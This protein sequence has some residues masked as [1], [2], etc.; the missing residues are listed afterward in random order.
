MFQDGASRRRPRGF[1]RKSSISSSSAVISA[2]V[3]TEVGATGHI[4]T[5]SFCTQLPNPC[6]LMEPG[7]AFPQFLPPNMCLSPQPPHA[8]PS[9]LPGQEMSLELKQQH[10]GEEE[11]LAQQYYV[12][13]FY[14]Q[15][16]SMDQYAQHQQQHQFSLQHFPEEIKTEIPSPVTARYDEQK[17]SLYGILSSARTNAQPVGAVESWENAE[18]AMTRRGS[19]SEVD[20]P[21]GVGGLPPFD[22]RFSTPWKM[23]WEQEEYCKLSPTAQ[24]QPR[25]ST[26]PA[27]TSGE[28]SPPVP[29]QLMLPPLSVPHKA[30][31]NAAMVAV[32]MPPTAPQ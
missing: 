23:G 27:S 14:N 8:S 5:P 25:D 32:A 31:H 22:R 18:L 12:G 9:P 30:Q 3:I 10:S 17:N 16:V 4:P 26:G 1:R 2:P 19:Y 6:V 7:M 28:S 11:A 20:G 24:F 13:D 29:G 21:G 15:V